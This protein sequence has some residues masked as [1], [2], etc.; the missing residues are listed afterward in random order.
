MTQSSWAAGAQERQRVESFV[1]IIFLLFPLWTFCPDVSCCLCL[2]LY[3]CLTED[4]VIIVKQCSLFV[5]SHYS[6]HILMSVCQWMS[7]PCFVSSC[8]DT[9]SLSQSSDVVSLS[10]CFSVHSN[11]G[12]PPLCTAPWLRSWRGWVACTSTTASAACRPSRPRIRAPLSA[13]GS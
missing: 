5:Y 4:I 8:S 10:V 9:M 1:I 7:S 13:C 2:C 3:V 12:R 6:G 11:K